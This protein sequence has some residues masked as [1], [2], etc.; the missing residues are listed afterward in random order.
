ML[1]AAC[2]GETTAG[3]QPDALAM[4]DA[5][6]VGTVEAPTNVMR[7][8]IGRQPFELD[9]GICN[10]YEDGTFS[11][12]LAE[13]PFDS[14]G[15]VTATIERFDTG[16]GFDVIIALEGARSDGTAVSWYAQES[17]EVHNISSTVLGGTVEGTALFASVGGPEA[18]GVRADGSFT[19]SCG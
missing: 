9:A 5:A 11:F 12:A 18:A 7:F 3:Q 15:R 19:V 16:A 6:P 2:S 4:T 14:A 13:G 17:I 1:L 8:T 10:T